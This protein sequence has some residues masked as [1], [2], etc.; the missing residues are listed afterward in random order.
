MQSSAT[1]RIKPF[2]TAILLA[3][4]LIASGTV[5]LAVFAWSQPRPS[6]PN[7][8][9]LPV[10][11]L[12]Y[13]EWTPLHTSPYAVPIELWIRCMAPTPAEWTR[14]RHKYGPHTQHYIQVY[15]NQ[16]AIQTLRGHEAWHFLTGAVIA[17]EKLAGSPDGV[18][19]G[20]AFMIK[21]GTPQ[22]TKTGGW[23]F[24]FYPQSGDSHRTQE[25]CASCHR[26]AVSTDYVFGQYPR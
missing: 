26:A 13:K 6:G 3:A 22:F 17:K 2:C 9:N 18:A 10:E 21:R 8:L 4:G 24:V 14:A 12:K 23:E 19:E 5:I 11:F 15:G 7:K 20:V 1:W 25:A 16:V